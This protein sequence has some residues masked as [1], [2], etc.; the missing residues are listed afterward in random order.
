MADI[1]I[2]T[3]HEMRIQMAMVFLYSKHIP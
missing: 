1:C 3:A 2:R